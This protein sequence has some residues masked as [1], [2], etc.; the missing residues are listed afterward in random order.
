MRCASRHRRIT[1]LWAKGMYWF[2][3]GSI[4]FLTMY[5]IIPRLMVRAVKQ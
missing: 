3:G 2:T 1:D 4:L 5:R